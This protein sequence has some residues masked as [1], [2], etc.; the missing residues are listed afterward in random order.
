MAVRPT[1]QRHMVLMPASRIEILVAWH[2]PAHCDPAAATTC[3]AAVP[4]AATNVTLNNALFH[5]GGDDWPAIKLA[6]VT[7]EGRP[8][9][10]S[11]RCRR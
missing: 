3:P 1:L 2:D 7:F 6:Q 8:R 4:P 9:A 10:L 11:P 5:T